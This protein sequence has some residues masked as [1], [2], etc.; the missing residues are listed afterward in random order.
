MMRLRECSRSG[1]GE[2]RN[3]IN[4]A[5][6]PAVTFGPGDVYQAHIFNESIKKWRSVRGL[7]QKDLAKRVGVSEMTIVNSEKGRTEPTKKNLERLQ[8]FLSIESTC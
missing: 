3:F 8:K 2:Y 4:D 1:P 7:F 6:I 5:K